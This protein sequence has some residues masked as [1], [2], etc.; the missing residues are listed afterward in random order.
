[1][2]EWMN[3]NIFSAESNI[4][5]FFGLNSDFQKPGKIM[6]KN[7]VLSQLIALIK[8]VAM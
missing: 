5:V 2:N 8:Y 1:M 6:E 4:S 3:E 7:L